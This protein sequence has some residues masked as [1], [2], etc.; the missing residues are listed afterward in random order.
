MYTYHRMPVA[1]NGIESL[2][3]N[4]Y[5]TAIKD[6]IADLRELPVWATNHAM[7]LGTTVSNLQK[8]GKTQAIEAMQLEIQKVNDDIAKAWKVRQ[9][10]DQYLPQWMAAAGQAQGSGAPIVP[11]VSQPT[12][13]PKVVAPQQQYVAPTLTQD[14]T[15]WVKS[16]FVDGLPQERGLGIAPLIVISASGIAALSY[17][18]TVGMSLWQDYKFKKDLTQNVIEGKVTSGQMAQ[19]LTAARPPETVIDKLV[20]QTGGNLATIA[21]IGAVGYAAFWYMTSKKALS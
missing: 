10:I 8:L 13:A 21:I 17:V 16:W 1:V 9:Y 20:A 14:V 6:K 12:T 2:N 3:F 15:G 11:A 5:W 7:K 4:S 19:I 18:V